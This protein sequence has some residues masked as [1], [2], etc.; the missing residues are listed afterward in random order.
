MGIDIVGSAMPADNGYGQ[1][2]SRLP[3]STLPGVKTSS[4]FLPEVD[5]DVAYAA[6]GG[7][8]RAYPGGM[9]GLNP[10][11]RSPKG[12]DTAGP[13]TRTLDGA[14]VPVAYGMKAR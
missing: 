14:N 12:G 1:N 9:D 2:G 10:Y 4:G 11:H 6:V 7:S 8:D 13:Q 3:S 5:L